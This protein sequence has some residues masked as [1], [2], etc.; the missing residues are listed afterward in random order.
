VSNTST[1][2]FEI[3]DTGTVMIG[4]INT[5]D[6]SQAFE[7]VVSMRDN[8]EKTEM[9]GDYHDTNVSVKVVKLSR[10]NVEIVDETVW[11]M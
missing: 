10:R 9:P 5:K 6:I 1:D 8:Q 11:G 4:C 2:K 3:L 7:L